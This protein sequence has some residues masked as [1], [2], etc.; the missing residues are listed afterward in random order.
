MKKMKSSGGA[1]STNDKGFG[2]GSKK[3]II[4][5]STA[6]STGKTKGNTAKFSKGKKTVS[7]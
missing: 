3:G 1:E 5:S 4:A 7:K 6:S 2:P